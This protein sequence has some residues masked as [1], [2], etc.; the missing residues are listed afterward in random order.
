MWQ[1]PTCTH[2]LLKESWASLLAHL[3]CSKCSPVVRWKEGKAI[4]RTERQHYTHFG[5]NGKNSGTHRL[6]DRRKYS[7]IW[8]PHT[9]THHSYSR[10]C[11]VVLLTCCHVQSVPQWWDR[12][13]ARQ[14]LELS[15]NTARINGWN[16]KNIGTY[17]LSW[18]KENTA[19]CDN[20]T[21]AHTS[22]SF[23]ESWSSLSHFLSCS[24]CSPVVR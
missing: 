15:T 5:W 2:Q 8:Q 23:K 16:G 20:H 14:S 17:H 18:E 13:K 24:K 22:Q 10:S 7:K 6:W 1:P 3:S 21:H 4:I 12:K 19:R 11:E 9:C